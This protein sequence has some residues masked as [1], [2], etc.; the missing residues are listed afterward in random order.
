MGEK[1]LNNKLCECGCGKIVK[2]R[3]I[4]G[5]NVFLRTKTEYKEIGEKISKKMLGHSVS[6]DTRNK[7]KKSSVGK[8]Y[9]LNTEFK[10]GQFKGKSYSEIYGKDRAEVIKN[11]ISNSEKGKLVLDVSRQKIRLA[12]S[13]KTYIELYGEE[14]AKIMRETHSKFMKEKWK[15]VEYA[16]KVCENSVMGLLKCPTS[17]EQKIC[18]L[19][20]KYNL[21]FI[22]KGNGSFLINYK[23]PDFVDEIDKIVIEVFYSWYKIRDY[24]SVDNYKEFCRK[25]YNPNGWNVIFIDENDLNCKNWEEVC[26]NIIKRAL[27]YV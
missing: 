23:N 11:K 2:R 21:P 17:Y 7:I 14:K 4:S 19:C 3:F 24:G 8:H 25:R 6:E 12:K 1:F 20:L 26:L 15:D 18:D 10:K 5:H 13:G 27:Q 22:Y 9:S 16:K